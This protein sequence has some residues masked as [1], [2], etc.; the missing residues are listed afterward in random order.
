MEFSS[1]SSPGGTARPSA[2]R[3]TAALTGEQVGTDARGQPLFPREAQAPRATGGRER[4]WVI[5]NGANDASR[6]PAEWHGWL[7]GSLRRRARKPSA[8]GADLGSRL[9]AQRHRHRRRL[10]PDGR[11]RARRP[12]RGGYRRLRKPGP[13]TPEHAPR[14]RR[15][16]A[17][18]CCAG[19]L[20]AAAPAC[21]RAEATEVPERPR[22][23]HRARGEP[24]GLGTPRERAG[25]NA[26]PAQQAQQHHRATSRSSRA[27][28]AAW[29]T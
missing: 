29:A 4:R 27:N 22:Q 9:H 19:R 7:H 20:Q 2:P 8:A 5:Y 1:R 13:R 10:S 14:R 24:S 16:C 15:F 3:S 21:P 25:R 28:R 11:A 12:P 23:R 18:R 6:V 26:R 17:L